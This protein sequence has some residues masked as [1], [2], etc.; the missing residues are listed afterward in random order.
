MQLPD[1]A[2][3]LVLLVATDGA[4]W[5]PETLRGLR[6]QKHRPIK[7]IAVDNAS[8]DGSGDMLTKAFGERRV[9]TLERRVGYG[10]ALAAALKVAAERS[11]EA[12]AFLL[13]HD[14]TCLDP[15]AIEQMIEALGE[16]NV[17]IVG[18]KLLDW[19][20]RDV[21]Q[22]IG[23]TTD[24]YGRQVPRVER[25]EL[26]QGQ[27]EGIEE[28]LYASSAALLIARDVVAKIGLFD[29]RYV[30][31]RDDLDLCWRARMAGYRT[32]VQTEAS[33]RHVRA[34]E[35]ELR[36]AP[37]RSRSRYY[38][39]RNMIV[40]VIKNYSLSR[41]MLA[42]PV[43]IVISLWNVVLFL[44]TGR[45]RAALQ[46]LEA[47][48]WNVVHLPSTLR[49]RV[50]AQH[51][52]TVD[53]ARVT[54]MM[55]HGAT[56]L[57]AQFER[58][59]E[60]VVGTPEET[61]DEDLDTEPPRII[62][63]LRA[64]PAALG[65]ILIV[66]VVLIGARGL[67]SS[68]DLA[69]ADLAPFPD[70]ARDLFASFASGWR[71]PGSGGAAPATPALVLLGMLTFVCFGSGWFA[72]RACLVGLPV[73]GGVLMSRLARTLGVST[74]VRRVAGAAY[75]LTPL[76]LGAYGAGRVSDLVLFAAAPGLMISVLR[77]GAILPRGGWREV[78]AGVAG[79]AVTASFAPWA[80]PLVAG[81]GI[82]VAGIQAA[83]RLRVVPV[84]RRIA[85]IVGGSLVLLL[86][87]STELFKPGSPLGA[88]GPDPEATMTDLLALTAGPIRPI[89]FA[90]SFGLALAAAGG[91]MIARG[92]RRLPA[93][94]LGVLS[95][96]GLLAA[97][98]VA[99]GVPWIA[100]RASLPL[101]VAA[102]SFTTLAAIGVETAG[103]MLRA[104]R[105]GTLHLAS[106]VIGLVVL[107][108]VAP[109]L[110][111]V[112]RGE[113]VGIVEAGSLVP[114]FFAGEAEQ[115]GAF[116]VLWV[117]GTADEPAVALT[118]PRGTSIESF[119][120]RPV[121]DGAATLERIVAMIAGG[122]TTVGGRM[123]STMGVRYVIVRPEAG[124]RLSDEIG[125]QADLAFSQRFRDATIYR[126][127]V[128]IPVAVPIADEAWVEASATGDLETTVLAGSPLPGDGFVRFAPSHL[129]GSAPEATKQILLAED[130]SDGWRARHGSTIIEPQRS[131]GWATRFPLTGPAGEVV[132]EWRGQRWH[133]A[134]MLGQFLLLAA[135]GIGWSQ[136][137]GR[138]RGER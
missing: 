62:D 17:G 136:R 133:R 12:D 29:N 67:L 83:R 116:R 13:L 77:A 117:G 73:L 40:T 75:A 33:A 103:S 125:R 74:G 102:V 98:A 119:L 24:R 108:Q 9:V 1:D 135:F 43:T 44:V 99:R 59:V 68:G 138:E 72:Q 21:L 36:Q 49:A 107:V 121:G 3:V 112:A 104:R 46:V 38:A 22:D 113:R 61:T 87:W 2:A 7:I 48:Q 47:L 134:A 118:G 60:T 71:G 111:W 106:G 64:H 101:T 124:P 109:A 57:R 50:R 92:D 120:A 25:G 122:S 130:Y 80:L 23:R 93:S 56:R 14:D 39:E 18:C 132:I 34:G 15:G 90:V 65:L 10:R 32:V 81:S 105:F 110:G 129:R 35:R 4:R 54:A 20:D 52:R 95:A 84:L 100:P 88:G 123:L 128:D 96:S 19:D 28:V 114:S 41:L 63:R 82:V 69:G 127:T 42:L 115:D 27:Y 76:M 94:V 26:D 16:D 89:P 85:V 37:P 79:L 137:A 30:V 91:L 97:W 45:R 5:L 66:V 86:P 51:A 53:D 78:A 70:R 8:T 55:H 126:T 31:L 131:F 58:A 6:A 11:M